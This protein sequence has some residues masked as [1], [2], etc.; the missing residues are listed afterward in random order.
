VPSF[1]R[2]DP[3]AYTVFRSITGINFY[4]FA[5]CLPHLLEQ[6]LLYIATDEQRRALKRRLEKQK[7]TL[8]EEILHQM[9]AVLQQIIEGTDESLD[10]GDAGSPILSSGKSKAKNR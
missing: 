7:S 4:T 10:A 9:Q 6:A 5:K 8:Q 3:V 1:Q 2:E